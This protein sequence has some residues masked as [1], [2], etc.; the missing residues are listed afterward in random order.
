MVMA[1]S[2]LCGYGAAQPLHHCWLV[3][4]H[5]A[6]MPADLAPLSVDEQARRQSGRIDSECRLRRRID[7]ERQRLDAN[8]R[9]ELAGD[10]GPLLIDVQRYHLES[11]AAELHLQ[12]VERRHLFATRLAPRR[13]DI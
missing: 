7:V 10:L 13:P 2:L 11:F 3:P 5:R 4:L 1:G 8:L 12:A 9:V 6:E